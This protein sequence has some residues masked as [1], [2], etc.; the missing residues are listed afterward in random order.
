LKPKLSGGGKWEQG[1]FKP[2]N[3]KK[4]VGNPHKIV[5]R[6]WW[7]FCFMRKLDKDPNVVAWQSEELVI[8]YRSP[9]DR[10]M[11]RYFVDFVY[12]T[13]DGKTYMVELKPWAQT[14]PPKKGRKNFLKESQTF[15]INKAKWEAAMAY[16]KAKGFIFKIVT[17]RELNVGK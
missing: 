12:R 5:Y 14:Q 2:L 3:P 9:K 1:P 13:K 10:Q 17:E 15:G 6:S 11:H 16:C 8:P 7:E 4:Y